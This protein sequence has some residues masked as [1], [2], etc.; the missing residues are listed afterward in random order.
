MPTY[1]YVCEQG[2]A[3]DIRRGIK[4]GP[5]ESPQCEACGE[6]MKRVWMVAEH[7][8]RISFNAW[9]T[10]YRTIIQPN[11]RKVKEK[12]RRQEK[13]DKRRMRKRSLS[14]G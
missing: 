5:P 8:P 3:V 4:A 1:S 2:H 12:Q 13:L 14:H 6:D 7:I 10:M 9:D 11:S